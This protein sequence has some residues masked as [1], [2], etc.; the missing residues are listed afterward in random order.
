MPEDVEL[1]D[2]VELGLEPVEVLAGEPVVTAVVVV[3]APPVPPAP[4]SPVS[5]PHA[6]TIGTATTQ[7]HSPR[8][9][10]LISAPFARD[11]AHMG[12]HNTIWRGPLQSDHA[13][14]I[15]AASNKSEGVR[16]EE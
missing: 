5:S 2:D 3:V 7:A 9:V 15:S 8:C 6:A 1:P 11:G 14:A 4:P 10:S 16:I 13:P 12:R